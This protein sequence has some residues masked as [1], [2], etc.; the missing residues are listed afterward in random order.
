MF[1]IR[2]WFMLILQLKTQ[3]VAF[4][5]DYTNL[6]FHQQCT[7]LFSSHPHQHLSF[8]FFLMTVILTWVR[9]LIV[10]CIYAFLMMYISTYLFFICMSSLEKCL[11]RSSAHF[12]IYLFI[13]LFIFD[14]GFCFVYFCCCLVGWVFLAMS[15]I[16]PLYILDINLLIGI[17][18]QI[19]EQRARKLTPIWSVN[20]QNKRQK[21]A[22]GKRQSLH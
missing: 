21:F 17:C 19:A 22:S 15:F 5:R 2:S 4:H 7:R 14:I 13:Y 16:R 3:Y 11:F 6:H 10:V 1:Y 8:V 18:L 9:Y 12:L 20:L